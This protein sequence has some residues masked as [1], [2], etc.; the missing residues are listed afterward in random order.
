MSSND[1]KTPTEGDPKPIYSV[2]AGG[3]PAVSCVA[4]GR[5]F[6]GRSP[7]GYRDDAPICDSCL[8]QADAELGMV[9][10]VISINRAYATLSA[11]GSGEWLD[12]LLE[13]GA[14]ARVYEIFAKRTGPPRIFDVSGLVDDEPAPQESPR[15]N[16]DRRPS[17]GPGKVD[18]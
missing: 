1:S 15:R 8:L 6:D 13:L 5:R 14:F 12:P 11:Q 18:P 17:R 2:R 16:G 7:S 3:G 10:A 4:C 9:L